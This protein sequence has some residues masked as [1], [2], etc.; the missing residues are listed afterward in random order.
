M[1]GSVTNVAALRALSGATDSVLYLEGYYALADGGEGMFVYNSGDTTS[2][3]NG[4]TIIVDAANRRWYR[5]YTG[6]V[7]VRWFG[8]KADG[9]SDDHTAIQTALNT[10]PGV[11]V[12]SG[13][14]LIKSTLNIGKG[15]Q[16]LYGD[17]STDTTILVY[18]SNTNIPAITCTD[19]ISN[20]FLSHLT[21]DR[22][23]TAVSGGDG[24][25]FLNPVNNATIT[26]VVCQNHYNGFTL[27]IINGGN[28]VDCAATNNVNHG[29]NI[30][31]GTLNSAPCQ[32]NPRN[33]AATRNSG[34]GFHISNSSFAGELPTSTMVNCA[35]YANTGHGVGAYGVSNNMSVAAIR[36]DGGFF[37]QD[38]GDEIYLDTYDSGHVIQADYIELAGTAYTG[39]NSN[40]PQKI[41]TPPSQTSCGINITQHNYSATIKCGVIN[42]NSYDGVFINGGRISIVGGLVTNNGLGKGGGRQNGIYVYQIGSAVIAVSITGCVIMDTG[43]GT[44]QLGIST[45]ADLLA[46]SGCHCDGNLA[47]PPYYFPPGFGTVSSVA[48][49]VP[50][51]MNI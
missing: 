6:D 30:T 5:D 26:D 7:S 19:N 4:G 11:Y 24:I 43:A 45:T 18:Q 42:G 13:N 39:R 50:R 20:F 3:D 16:N 40:N 21:I 17:A 41:G 49:C 28:T 8:A 34:D 48:G 36:I 10:T 38:N 12:P 47:S 29:F 51:S 14:Y 33:C 25:Q 46:V 9:V 15:G 44:Q 32:W 31:P 1:T 23:G 37:G 22:Q 27:G 35:T 2:L